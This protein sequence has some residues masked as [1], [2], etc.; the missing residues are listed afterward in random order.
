VTVIGIEP[1]TP[2]TVALITA[3]PA[4]TPVTTPLDTDATLGAELDQITV[5]PVNVWP[6]ASFG[7][8]VTDAVA[9]TR[10]ELAL[11]ETVTELTGAAGAAATVIEI[12]PLLPSLV[13]VTVADPA[14]SACTWPDGETLSTLGDELDQ[15][16]VR[17]ESTVPC[18]SFSVTLIDCACPTVSE[19]ELALSATVATGAGA[20]VLTT[21]VAEPD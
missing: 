9:P 16:M 8:A 15:A 10:I 4:A 21:S 13:A 19:D 12:V 20:A 6:I 2:S 5:L 11:P 3:V 7:V 14:A 17:P 1:T 18:A